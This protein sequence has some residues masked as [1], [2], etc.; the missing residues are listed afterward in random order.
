LIELFTDPD[1]ASP[2][3]HMLSNPMYS[4]LWNFSI[5]LAMPAPPV[6]KVPKPFQPNQTYRRL[7]IENL[8]ILNNILYICLSTRHIR[9]YLLI[10]H[11]QI[12]S[13]PEWRWSEMLSLIYWSAFSP[14]VA[15][16]RRQLWPRWRSRELRV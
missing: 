14:H 11:S 7:I 16:P 13:K 9:T 4:F 8:K 15:P 5:M 2:Y 3:E 10:L 1:E 6:R 12:L